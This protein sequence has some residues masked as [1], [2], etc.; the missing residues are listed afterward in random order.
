MTAQTGFDFDAPFDHRR[1]GSYRWELPEGVLGLGTA[2][3]DFACA[4]CLREELLQV[5]GENCYNYRRRPERYFAAA[6]GWFLRNFGLAIDRGWL[7]SVPGTIGAIR[8]AIDALSRPGDR[9][10]LHS[11][12]FGPLVK[13]VEGA[14]R[15]PVYCPLQLSGD[16]YRLDMELFRRRVSETRPALLLL[17]NPHNPTGMAFEAAELAK[18]AEICEGAGVRIVSDEVHCLV[19]LGQKP[20]VPLLAAGEAA[21]R[22][23]LQVVSLSKGYNIMSLPHALVLVADPEVRRA[24]RQTLDPYAF[25]YA[26]N[27]FAVAAATV[28]MEGRGEDWLRQL[29]DYL[30]C[31]LRLVQEHLEREGLPLRL[32]PPQGGFLLWLDC[33]GAGFSENPGRVFLEKGRIHLCGGEEFGPEGRGFV[34]LNLGTTRAV[35]R[36]ALRRMGELSY[37]T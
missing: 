9:V 26:A 24:Y 7:F 10:L 29:R 8:I 31:N 35:L 6:E 13:A 28:L 20:H 37:G 21:R 5:A 4:P 36:E 18:M 2:D 19:M 34:R 32:I 25:G 11:P 27:S 3:L 1:D 14:G 23:G 12:A 17:V 22:V 16:G 30:L 15:Q 33:R